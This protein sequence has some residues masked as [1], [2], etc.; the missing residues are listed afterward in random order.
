MRFTYMPMVYSGESRKRPDMYVSSDPRWP[1][2][3]P[4]WFHV[5]NILASL[6][7]RRAFHGVDGMD[8]Y[9][10]PRPRPYWKRPGLGLKR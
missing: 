5:E 1:D 9:C 8:T 3:D 6:R 10:L 7:T 2:D 4:V